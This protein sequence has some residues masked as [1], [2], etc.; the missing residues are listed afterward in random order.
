MPG[1]QPPEVHA[2]NPLYLDAAMKQITNPPRLINVIS[3][4]VR[5]LNSG[6][7]P[8]VDVPPRT[9]PLDIAL[10]EVAEGKLTVVT[11]SALLDPEPGE[12]GHETPE[13]EKA[14]A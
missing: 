5:Q 7:R 14:T 3:R 8:L 10:M 2:L 11:A 13:A 12:A 6:Q 9:D 4:R 1:G